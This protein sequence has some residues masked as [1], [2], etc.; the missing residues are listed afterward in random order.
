MP[1]TSLLLK[2]GAV[3]LSASTAHVSITLPGKFSEQYPGKPGQVTAQ[4]GAATI[5]S[6]RRTDARE[7]G[8]REEG[9]REEGAREESARTMLSPGAGCHYWHTA[10]STQAFQQIPSW[11]LT[12]PKRGSSSILKFL[13][14]SYERILEEEG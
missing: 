8:A 5:R 3:A 12:R 6:R 11:L 4:P 9:A 13:S 2:T 10:R 7:E 1:S 14:K